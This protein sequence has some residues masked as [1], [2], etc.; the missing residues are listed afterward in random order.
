MLDRFSFNSNGETIVDHFTYDD[1]VYCYRSML[2]EVNK[3]YYC[4]VEVCKES[5]YNG[6]LSVDDRWAVI[7]TLCDDAGRIVVSCKRV[8]IVI[9]SFDQK[10]SQFMNGKEFKFLDIHD[11]AFNNKNKT[12]DLCYLITEKVAEL[13]DKVVTRIDKLPKT[14]KFTI[15]KLKEYRS[16]AGTKVILSNVRR[17]REYLVRFGCNFTDLSKIPDDGFIVLEYCEYSR[18]IVKLDF[19]E[20]DDAIINIINNSNGIVIIK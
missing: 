6:R 11:I 8:V 4:R 18:S 9:S 14:H 3:D 13:V 7:H 12:G 10:F 15:D 20:P 19:I 16:L 2:N 5:K 1:M 17:L